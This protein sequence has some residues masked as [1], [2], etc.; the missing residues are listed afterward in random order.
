MQDELAAEHPEIP[1]QIIHVNQAGYNDGLP[2]LAAITD[3]PILQDDVITDVWVNW[4]AEWRD[5]YVLGPRNEIVAIY[6]LSEQSLANP[7]HYA[8]LKALM[9]SA[10]TE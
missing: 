9:I 6:N 1:L 8:E 3:L 2:D 7:D 10:W 4:G 5:V